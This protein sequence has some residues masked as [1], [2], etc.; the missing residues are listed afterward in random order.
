MKGPSVGT[1]STLGEVNMQEQAVGARVLVLLNQI[2]SLKIDKTLFSDP[3]YLSLRDYTIQVPSLPVGRA[4]PFAPIP[5]MVSAT[6][7]TK[8]AT[9]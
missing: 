2:N 9:R 4:N 1:S 8:T 5:G 6:K 3:A 7:E